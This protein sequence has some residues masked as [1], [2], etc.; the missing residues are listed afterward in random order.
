MLGKTF[1]T[2]RTR[3]I[4][5]A[6][7]SVVSTI[8]PAENECLRF[9]HYSAISF[10]SF[11]SLHVLCSSY[12]VLLLLFLLSAPA[13]KRT[14]LHARSTWSR[15]RSTEHRVPRLP[16]PPHR[17]PEV[18]EITCHRFSVPRALSFSSAFAEVLEIT[19]R[20]FSVPNMSA[21]RS[22]FGGPGAPSSGPRGGPRTPSSGPGSGSGGRCLVPFA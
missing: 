16:S 18:L 7:P 22:S 11:P 21:L 13:P 6:V 10:P 15:A 14:P 4:R 5:S 8:A 19:S 12:S 9:I 2:F 3:G 20:R 17:V 1:R